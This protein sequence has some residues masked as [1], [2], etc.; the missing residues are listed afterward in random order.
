MTSHNGEP[1]VI[2]LKSISFMKVFLFLVRAVI[3]I[4]QMG[5]LC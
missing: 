5:E 3:T 2:D 4:T 1:I